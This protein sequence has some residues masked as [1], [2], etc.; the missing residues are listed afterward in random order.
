MEKFQSELLP[1][2][3]H[4]KNFEIF[5]TKL[6][7]RILIPRLFEWS[8]LLFSWF[9]L[10]FFN[11]LDKKTYSLQISFKWALISL[12]SL[13]VIW[14]GF[15]RS[16]YNSWNCNITFFRFQFSSYINYFPRSFITQSVFTWSKLKAETLEPCSSV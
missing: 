4:L 10:I 5:C 11:M 6:L 13:S 8:W 15:F 1:A 3:C 14:I 12:P 7:L 2:N 16:Q 9:T